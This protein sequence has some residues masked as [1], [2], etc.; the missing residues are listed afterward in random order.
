MLVKTG[1]SDPTAGPTTGI[2]WHMALARRIEFVATDEAL[3][4]V[5]WVRVIDDRTGATRIFRSDGKTSS[6]PPPAGVRRA[7][8]CMDCHNRA[9][10]VF[11]SPA[12]AADNA[13]NANPE[14]RQAPFAKREL[15]AAVMQSF[16]SREEGLKEAAATLKAYYEEHYPN[17]DETQKAAVDKLAKAAREIYRINFFPNMRAD[18]RTYP[19]NIGHFESAGCFRC[20]DGRHKD[21]S[22]AE[23]ISAC[24]T[25]HEFLVANETGA[26]S[27]VR[28]DEFVH[29]VELPGFHAELRCASC[30]SGG[31][32]PEPTCE[33]CHT[34]VSA[35]R[36]GTT[37][38]LKKFGI[39]AEPMN[40]LVGCQDCHDVSERVKLDTVNAA[41]LNCHEADQYGG[42]LQ[43]W[44]GEIDKKASAVRDDPQTHDVLDRLRRAGALHNVDAARK[45]L[46]AL[47]APGPA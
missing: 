13:L 24:N 17:L 7:M 1:G 23:I 28:S 33:G 30:H 37:P 3:Q 38:E 45:I 47:A 32:L 44:K 36:A 16:G 26:E 25:C 29:P 21:D 9:T 5:P 8:D 46:D 18:W 41:C 15:T 27:L 35:F 2:H 11:R 22:G 34:D 20:H 14:L 43:R 6:D 42:I 12:D 19:N 31:V 39:A 40:E 10:H 4:R